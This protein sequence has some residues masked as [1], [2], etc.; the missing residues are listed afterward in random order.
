MRTDYCNNINSEKIDKLVTICGWV[1]KRRDH[2][3]VIFTD[4]RDK[5]GIV[6]AV[7]KPDNKKIF[8]IAKDIRNEYVLKITGYVVARDKNTI[9][10]KIP[11]GTVEIETNEV[12]ILNKAKSLPFLLD[13]KETSEAVR[14]QYR[15]LDLRKN[16]IQAN[17]RT[18]SEITTTIRNFLQKNDFLDIE[19][20]ILNKSTPEGARDYL[21]PSRIYKGHFFALPQSPQIFK[22]LLMV[23]GFEKYYQIARCF[24]DEDL[25]ANRQPEFTQIDL[26]VSFVEENDIMSLAENMIRELF[27]KILNTKLPKFQVISY[28]KAMN[29]YGSDKPDL[30]YDLKLVKI[31][32]LVKDVDFKVFAKPACDKDSKVVALRV[33]NGA[34]TLSRSKIDEYTKFVAK[35]QAKGLAY[36]K[37]NQDNSLSS[38]IIKFLPQDCVNNIIKNTNS[39]AG[40]IIFFGADKKDIVNQSLANLR[41][42]LAK[43]LNLA[44]T[45][46]A[47]VWIV[48]FP[49][50]EKENNVLNSPHHPFTKPKGDKKEIIKQLKS[51]PLQLKSHAYDMVINGEE[52][53][54]G[55]IR[56]HNKSIQLSVLEL[57]G[58]DKNKAYEKF[59][60]MLEA[61][62]Y[63]S[64]PHG[65]IAFGLDRLVMLITN[66]KSIRD[67]IAFPKTQN[68]NCLLTEAPS[69]IDKEQLENLALKL[70]KHKK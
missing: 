60:F 9:N 6:Q 35:F 64:P 69:K 22:Q 25:R 12:I 32:D 14:L 31:N 5:S 13:D 34:N 57:L 42:L 29:D 16:E 46:W 33:P 19:T 53:G 41:I 7:F 63:G 37:I 52:I 61:L 24:R 18:R 21:V 62:E 17:I 10:P 58:I 11:S 70:L 20:P 49:L 48:D 4:I 45:K 26:E 8:D 28:K 39:Q 50:F 55:S 56:I 15:Y 47:P 27:S 40:D 30:R 67:V 43:D 65:G 3:G 54:G 68:T 36:I 1:N 2:G 44:T 51:N 66:S 38:P 59:G 23:A